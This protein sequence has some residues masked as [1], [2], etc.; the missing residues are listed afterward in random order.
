MP[1][2]ITGDWAEIRSVI[3]RNQVSSAGNKGVGNAAANCN[4]ANVPSVLAH[5]ARNHTAA[6]SRSG[7]LH[8]P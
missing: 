3:A 8:Q 1:P 4:A 6:G 2:A 7:V 5:Q